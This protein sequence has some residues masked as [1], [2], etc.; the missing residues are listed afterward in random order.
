MLRNR[1]LERLV[2]KTRAFRQPDDP[3]AGPASPEPRCRLCLDSVRLPGQG[4]LRA[5]ETAR[6]VPLL[7][8]FSRY[9][10]RAQAVALAAF[11][12][13]LCI[14]LAPAAARAGCSPR[15]HTHSDTDRLRGVRDPIMSGASGAAER[16]PALPRMPCSGASCSRLP[17]AP[18]VPAAVFDELPDSWVFSAPTAEWNVFDRWLHMSNPD[19]L[20]PMRRAIAVFHPPRFPAPV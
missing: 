14:L 5:K 11:A 19:A 13:I 18:S 9:W 17:D 12:V 8:R 1:P 6:A 3:I 20:L 15:V 2:S 10:R 7:T 4:S 16:P